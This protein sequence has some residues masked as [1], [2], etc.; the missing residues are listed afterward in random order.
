MNGYLSI[1]ACLQQC[2]DYAH[3]SHARRDKERSAAGPNLQA[4]CRPVH[5]CFV[6]DE[7]VHDSKVTFLTCDM[8][9]GR[10]PYCDLAPVKRTGQAI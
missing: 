8:D 7:G 3:M 1:C 4:G 9:R 2:L 6:L 10:M 5:I